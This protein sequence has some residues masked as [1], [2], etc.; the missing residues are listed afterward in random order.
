VPRSLWNGTI[1]FGLVHVPIKLYSATESK[2][3][4]FYEAH[5]PD[6]ARIAHRRF[7]TKEDREVPY[8]EV[9]RGFEVEPGQY[10]VLRREELAAA[11]AEHMRM[12]EVEHFVEIAQIDPVFF[13][14]AYYVG[15]D[16]RG[17]RAYRLLHRALDE[18]RRSAIGHFAFHGRE[19]LVAIRPFARLLVLH[20]LRFANEIGGADVQAALA[21]TRKP[22]EA[23]LTMA[24]RLVE[25][26]HEP[27]RPERYEDTYREAVLALITR[28]AANEPIEVAREDGRE[29]HDDLLAALKASLGGRS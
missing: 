9:V 13:D 16:E 22:S 23:E 11:A 21:D 7:C 19:Y 6:G 8:E 26:L 14:R 5:L 12:I 10:V 27:F 20:T 1:S 28:K 15:A 25:T 24:Q 17:E 4:R 18:T 3:V 29:Q 2:A